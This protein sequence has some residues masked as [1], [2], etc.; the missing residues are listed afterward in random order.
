MITEVFIS[1]KEIFDKIKTTPKSKGTYG[2]IKYQQ[3]STLPIYG[4]VFFKNSGE[5]SYFMQY[6]CAAIDNTTKKI[7]KIVSGTQRMRYD[8][9]DYCYDSWSDYCWED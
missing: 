7:A 6:F 4:L 1:K 3:Q 8:C 9:G 2:I 5:I